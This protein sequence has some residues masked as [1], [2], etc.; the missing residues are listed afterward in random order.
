[1]VSVS[2]LFVLFL[3]NLPATWTGTSTASYTP[4]GAQQNGRGHQQ[5]PL[6]HPNHFC[7]SITCQ[8]IFLSEMQDC[9][10]MYMVA[11]SYLLINFS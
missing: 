11:L 10:Y 5:P 6:H 2:T 8:S 7:M 3:H 1:M 9:Y 4:V